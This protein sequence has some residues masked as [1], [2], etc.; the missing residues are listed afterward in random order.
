MFEP[1]KLP[2][3]AEE[4]ALQ[5]YGE[6]EVKVLNKQYGGYSDAALIHSSALDGEWYDLRSYLCLSCR[7]MSMG[8]VINLL[9]TNTTQ[10][11]IVLFQTSPN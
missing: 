6:V 7:N 4:A 8:D 5:K 1:S 2:A 11:N 10:H 3:T 9:A